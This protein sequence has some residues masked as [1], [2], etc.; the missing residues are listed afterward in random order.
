MY[1]CV[2]VCVCL[3]VCQCVYHRR[4]SLSS[5]KGPI[6]FSYSQLFPSFH[7]FFF[8]FIYRVY[9]D[10]CDWTRSLLTVPSCRRLAWGYSLVSGGRC[11]G[12]RGLQGQVLLTQGY[13]WNHQILFFLFFLFF[14]LQSHF[15]HKLDLPVDEISYFRN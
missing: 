14:L 5:F 12:R 10:L 8:L 4:D 13:L 15:Q 3:C 11:L 9:N 6:L 7:F 2:C 1:V